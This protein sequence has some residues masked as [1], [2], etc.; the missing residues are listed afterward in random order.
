MTRLGFIY[1]LMLI[2]S[3]V[4]SATAAQPAGEATIEI[5]ALSHRPEDGAVL[6]LAT[7]LAIATNGV[8]V[9]YGDALLTAERV[10]VNYAQFEVIADGDVHIQQGEQVWVSQHVRYNFKSRQMQA[11]QFRTGQTP[12]FAEGSGLHGDITNRV[13]IATNAVLT[14]DDIAQPAFK[15]RAKRIKIIPNKKIEAYSATLYLGEVPVF[16]FP[17][18]TRNIGPHANNFNFMPGYR[19]LYGPFILGSYTWY[20]DDHLDGVFH[21][22]YRQKRGPGV[23]PDFNYHLGRW[24]EGTLRYY[25]T[26]DDDSNVDEIGVPIPKDRQRVYFSYDA[27]PATNL[28]V[29]SL[30]QYQ[31]DITMIRDFFEGEYRKNPQPETFLQVNKFW[32]NFSVDAFAQPRLNDFLQT[33]ERLPEI[34]LTGYRQQLGN[35]PLFYQSES[36]F[37]Y[38]RFQYA[39]NTGTLGPPPGL[40]YEAARGD[41]FHQ[42]LL[43]ETLFGWLNV[44][45]RVGGRV[46]YYSEASGPGATTDEQYRG[47]FNTGAEVSFKA[48]RL[49]QGVQNEFFDVNGLR[50]IVEPSANYVYVPN[51]TVA[52]NQLPQFDYELASLRLLPINFPDYNSIDSIDSQ[53]VIRWGL[54]NKLQTKRDGQI[55][56]V[57]NWDVYTDW[58]LKPH[59]D[60]TTFSD[61]YSDL[62]LTPRSWLSLES[63]TRFDISSGNLR[64]SFTTLS[65]QPNET[66]SWRIGHYYLRDDVSPSP[67]ALGLGNDVIS[68]T[69]HYRLNENWGFRASHYFDVRTGRLQEQSYTVYRDMRSWTAALSFLVRQQ[70]TGKPED[71]TVAFT[72]SLKAFPRFNLGTEAGGPYSLLGG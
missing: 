26:H 62:T 5:E 47:V 34:K 39:E 54:R 51:P 53:N 17:F 36:S 72:F 65:I 56:N 28:Y 46:T 22:D 44:T 45:P 43:P 18:Y 63:L 71:Y 69:L 57:V 24:G 42:V 3:I 32:Q 6:D 25:Y 14:S 2:W 37:G 11:E 23:G 8:K 35:S 31:S 12:I 41:T 1:A 40:D 59:S 10:A 60:Q 50:H 33:V 19:S 58:R 68:S 49:W 70:T 16:Y 67:T 38:Y 29:K 52:P 15:V 48:S 21:V 20:Y 13:Y 66:W 64:M 30:V 9:T 27:N 4:L 55:A 7:G 61:L